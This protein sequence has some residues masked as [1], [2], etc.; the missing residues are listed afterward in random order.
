MKHMPLDG[1]GRARCSSPLAS[2]AW[3]SWES[4]DAQTPRANCRTRPSARHRRRSALEMAAPIRPAP[5]TTSP[6][7]ATT[8]TTTPA[9]ALPARPSP[10]CANSIGNEPNP[11]PVVVVLDDGS[12]DPGAFVDRSRIGAI[13]Q[14][15]HL[16]VVAPVGVEPMTTSSSADAIVDAGLRTCIDLSRVYLVGFSGGAMLGS[17]IVCHHPGLVTAF[18]AVAGLL[19]PD[20]CAVDVRVPVLALQGELDEAVSPVGGRRCLERMG[21]PGW[22]PA[23]ILLG[24]GRVGHPVLRVP[25]T[26]RTRP[27]YSST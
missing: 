8:T 2:L 22:L 27:T 26:A 11:A 16:V 9:A 3:S 7:P 15:Q 24:G 23:R 19:P 4:E 20:G 6:P 21:S 1:G 5:V 10:G 12:G 25:R 17:R 13:A 18:V 14:A